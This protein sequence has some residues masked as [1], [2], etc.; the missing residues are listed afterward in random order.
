MLTSFAQIK[1]HWLYRYNLIYQ[2]L[3]ACAKIHKK[4]INLSFRFVHSIVGLK[5]LHRK[6]VSLKPKSKYKITL[7][8]MYNLE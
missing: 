1:P 3:Y 7:L 4:H 5:S 8:I 6:N 2:I